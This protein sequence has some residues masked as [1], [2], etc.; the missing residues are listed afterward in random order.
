MLDGVMTANSTE[1]VVI[2]NNTIYDRA[3]GLIMPVPAGW[4]AT[5]APGSL[6]GMQPRGRANSYFVAQELEGQQLQGYNVQD[7]VRTRLQQMGL[8]YVGSRQASARSGERFPVDAWVGQ[9]QSGQVGVETTQFP[10]GDHVAVFMFVAPNLN[11]SNSPLG[12][13]LQQATFDPGRARSVQPPR[14]QIGTVR[15]GESWADLARRATGNAGDAEAV[16]N[17]NG[18]DLATA[19]SSGMVVK[20]PEEVIREE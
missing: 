4:V 15:S 20:L 2:R 1:R 14:I 16:A 10:H 7:A 11:R 17:L 5:A 3:H 19:P 12:Q 9:T 8:Q 18:F 6:F 13:V